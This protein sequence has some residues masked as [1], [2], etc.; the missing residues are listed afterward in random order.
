MV[1]W[2]TYGASQERYEYDAY[3]RASILEPNFAA[4]ADGKSDYGN[5]YLFTGR[6][7]DFL[8]NGSLTL[9]YNRHRYYDYYTGRWTGQD[10][11]RDGGVSPVRR[12]LNAHPAGK[13]RRPDPSLRS[14]Q[15]MT[16]GFGAGQAKVIYYSRFSICACAR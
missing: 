1:T 5:P 2:T 10:A 3:G 6:R 4:E 9:Q 12:R 13:R 16:A 15:Q 7:V 14:P 11:L 8:D